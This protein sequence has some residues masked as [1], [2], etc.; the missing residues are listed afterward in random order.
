MAIVVEEEKKPVNWVALLTTIIII[1]VLFLGAYFLFFKK[2]ELIEVVVPGSLKEV[3]QLSQVSFDP[4]SVL[5]SPA[6]K[7]LRQY[8]TAITPAATGRSNP[9]LPF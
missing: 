7:L 9:F 2:P 5:S 4:D 3:S 6:F 1:V 8:G